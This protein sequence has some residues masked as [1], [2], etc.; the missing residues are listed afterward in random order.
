MN[1]CI[2]VKYEVDGKFYYSEEVK[3]QAMEIHGCSCDSCC[4]YTPLV[5]ESLQK[6]E[7]EKEF[8]ENIFENRFNINENSI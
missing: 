7:N 6:R 3:K 5:E 2:D 1:E 4:H 8:Y